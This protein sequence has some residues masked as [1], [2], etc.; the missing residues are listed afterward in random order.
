MY[1]RLIEINKLDGGCVEHVQLK[2]FES[3]LK[4]KA[5]KILIL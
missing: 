3:D 2:L 1:I 5:I 4:K